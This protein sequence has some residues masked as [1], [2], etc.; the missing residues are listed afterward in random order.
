MSHLLF[1]KHNVE[2][3]Y[4]SY[5]KEVKEK[6]DRMSD[7]EITGSELSDLEE[8]YY[9][10][11]EVHPL[12]IIDDKI[13]LTMEE[14]KNQQNRFNRFTDKNQDQY[15][16]IKINCKIPFDGDDSLLDY[17]PSIP[18]NCRFECELIVQPSPHECGIILVEIIFNRQA[19]E[20]NKDNM[21]EIVND[22]LK[23]RLA[24]LK[25][26]IKYVNDD[27]EDYNSKLRSTIH[28]ALNI[29][30]KRAQSLRNISQLLSIPLQLSENA[31]NTK[32]I[33]L[34]RIVKPSVPKLPPKQTR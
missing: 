23:R 1:S 20:Q 2:T 22:V 4:S 28:E 25:T 6:I 27:V 8:Y 12:Q 24:P 16:D 34:K 9:Q 10:S 14:I 32:P 13:L 30:I 31:P 11:Y 3:Y 19:L 33:V 7:I 17:A 5:L 21:Q 18:I 26:I 29:R 15:N